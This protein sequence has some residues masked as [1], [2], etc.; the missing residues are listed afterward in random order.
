MHM[1]FRNATRPDNP[2]GQGLVEFAIALPLLALLLVMAVDFG[3]VFFGWVALQNA[4]RIGADFAAQE[5]DDQEVYRNYVLNDLTAINCH[6]T[7]ALDADGDGAWDPADVPDPTFVDVNSNGVPT[8]DGDHAFVRLECQFDLLTPLAETVLGGP[9]GLGAEAYFAINGPLLA[10]LP[11]PAPPPPGPCPGPTADFDMLE[12]SSDPTSD[13]NDGQGNHALTIAFTDASTEDA[14][15]PITSWEWDFQ[16]DGTMDDTTAN[17]T[18]TFNY[19]GPGPAFKNFLVELTVSNGT[20]TSAHT[21]TI[22]VRRP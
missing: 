10:G 13:V 22:R 20:D 9:V 5:P 8:D 18:F 21:E 12:T 1:Q 2:R 4:A 16:S 15:C 14:D 17:P 19:P 11:D 3:R 7:P 6:P